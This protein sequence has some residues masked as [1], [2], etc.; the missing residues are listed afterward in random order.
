MVLARLAEADD[1]TSLQSMRQH[2]QSLST[3]EKEDCQPLKQVA[4]PCAAHKQKQPDSWC[5]SSLKICFPVEHKG[6]AGNK[7]KKLFHFGLLK[8]PSFLVFCI[9]TGLFTSAFKAA[10]TFIPA[11]VK[12]KNLSDSEAALVLSISGVFDTLGRIVSGLVLDRPLLRPYRPLLYN[13]FVFA[14]AA[15]SFILPSLRS[16]TTLSIMC[17]LYGTLTGAYISQKSVVLVDILGV[18]NMSSS[19]GLLI[20][21]QAIGTCV[22]PPLSGELLGCVG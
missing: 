19:F 20:F 12:S 1:S 17:S 15:V 11:L 14:I 7:K 13:S 10:F 3:S 6:K 18:E 5:L 9:S 2:R 22:G 4:S 8:D 21:F 16:F